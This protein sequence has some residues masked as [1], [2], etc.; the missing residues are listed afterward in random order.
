MLKAGFARLDITP[1]LGTPLSGYFH[2]RRAA[3]ILDPLY[4]NAVAVSSE[5]ETVILM[6]A[7]LTG[8]RRSY[9]EKIQNMIEERTGVPAKNIFLAAL[10][11][12]TSYVLNDASP[13]HP[14]DPALVDIVLRKMADAAVLAIADEKDARIGAAERELDTPIAF[15]RRYVAE[16]GS[17]HTN[18]SSSVKVTGRVDEAD[19]T[20]RVVRFFRDGVKDIAILNFSTHPDVIS[21]ESFSADWPGLARIRMEKTLGDV[22]C[23]FFTGAQGDSNH[24]DYLKPREERFFGDG[25]YDHAQYMGRAVA[26]T[27][28]AIWDGIEP[29]DGDEIYV[30]S[31]VI[32]N[33]TNTEGIEKYD[34]YRAWYNDYKAGK[35]KNVHIT[36]L[37]YATRIIGLRTAP[38]LHSVPLTVVGVGGVTLV[39]FGGEAFTAYGNAARAIT[40]DKFVISVVCANGHEGYLPTEKAFLEGGYEPRSSLFTPTLERELLTELSDMM[41]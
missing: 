39:G 30:D 32:Y 10:H 23:L 21:G 9:V 33:R 17:I 36:E 22:C 13:H 16:D 18:P 12:H 6:A 20:V 31:R 1:P 25:R 29:T 35:I 19:N 7:D 8:I 3:G 37:A 4:V 34:Y 40:P 11:Q 5:K 27:A 41:K 14:G 26:D 38:I 28:C 15:V 24:I 2:P